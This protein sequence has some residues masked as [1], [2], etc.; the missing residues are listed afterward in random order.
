[1][2]VLLADSL[3]PEAVER[4]VN[5]GDEV[6][7]RPELTADSLPG[8]I[9][10]F[11]AL[12]VRSTKVT[13]ETIAAADRLG[14]IVRAGAG[15]NT[16]DCD[17]A[18]EVG[19]FVCNVP[20]R[21]ALAV[22]E[23]TMGLLVAVDRHIASATADL[24]NG[25]W[26]KKVYSKAG[27][28]HGR[29]MGVIGLGDIGLAVTE[30][31]TAFGLD[32]VALAK[33]GRSREAID[34]AEQAG[35]RF[36]EDLATLLATSEI[37]SIHV[38]GAPDTKGLVDRAFLDQMRDGAILLNT[39]RGDVVDEAAL[40]DAL[41]TRGFR[42]GLDVFADEPGSG[43]GEFHSDLARHPNVTATHHIGASTEQAQEAVAAGTI[44]AI[45][46][47]GRGKPV[48][49]V[50]LEPVPARAATLTIR[51]RDR[52]GVLAAVLAILRTAQLNVSTMA[53]QV[54]AG[55][56]AAV[57]AIDVGHE[58]S[59]ETLAEIQNLEDVINVSISRP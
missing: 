4:L 57:A 51:H 44:D 54:F 18:A 2:R 58:P 23:L 35:L 52:V 3:P 46:A 30:R 8:A 55:S 19:I 40:I 17:R 9:A 1:M 41:D 56:N 12:V 11:E 42:A 45:E 34:R 25:V 7:V 15:T 28:L 21:N 10:G 13:A 48:N 39:S 31:A 6:V 26:N 24:R 53:N 16:I 5:A 36:V 43:S 27:G 32:V 37:V 33:P 50:N 20:G 47:Y 29:T 22:A 49:C 38:P 14:L 59:D